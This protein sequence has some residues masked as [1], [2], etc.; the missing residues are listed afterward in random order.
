MT[1]RADVVNGLLALFD[2]PSYLEIGVSEGETFNQV[3]AAR[4]VAVDPHFAFSA[5]IETDEGCAYHEV[6]SDAYFSTVRG[7]GER[8]HVVYLDGLHTFEQTLRDFVHALDVLEPNGVIVIDDVLPSSYASSLPDQR[9]TMLLRRA[10]G[11]TDHS[12]MGDTYKLVF[13][14]EAFFRSCRL[15]TVSDNHGQAVVWRG[16]PRGAAPVRTVREVADLGFVDVVSNPAAYHFATFEVIVAEV[17]A[18]VASPAAP[19][20]RAGD[21]GPA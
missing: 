8:F 20:M 21:R 13:F 6:T 2:A 1:S 7:P 18:H 19:Q 3:V 12:W 10:S 14:V 9:D 5:P 4:K 17:A 11:S 16:R 15:R